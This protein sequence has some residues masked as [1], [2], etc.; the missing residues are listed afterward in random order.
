MA[1]HRMTHSILNVGI[2]EEIATKMP[3]NLKSLRVGKHRKLDTKPRW[4]Q[5]NKITRA[6]YRARA[7]LYNVLPEKVTSQVEV[8][9]FKKELKSYMMEN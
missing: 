8:K 6:S 4:L 7:Y 2:P 3:M 1:T 9:K 5:K